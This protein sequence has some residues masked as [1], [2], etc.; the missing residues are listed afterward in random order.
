MKL[1]NV[2]KVLIEA[3]KK[4]YQRLL[5][6]YFIGEITVKC[7]LLVE[8]R[9]LMTSIVNKNVGHS[10][11]F[12]ENGYFPGFLPSEYY[13]CIVEGLKVKYKDNKVNIMW[14]DF[15]EY[16]LKLDIDKYSNSTDN[17]VSN[18]I[19]NLCTKNKKYDPDGEKPFF[20]TWVRNDKKQLSDENY[21]KT[22]R[23]FGY[24]IANLCRKQNVS[25]RWNYIEQK[26][27]LDILNLKKSENE[28][29]TLK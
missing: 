4:P 7:L 14:S 21:N 24:N 5:F 17:D 22:A 9:V 20:E 16:L 25:S 1:E 8:N 3:S 28:I 29:R 18:I 10:I 2:N 19:K 26:K 13:N 15:D 27:S 12:D 11:V 6:D 23:Y